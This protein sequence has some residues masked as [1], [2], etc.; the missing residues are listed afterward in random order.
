M[1]LEK[2]KERERFHW[3]KKFAIIIFLLHHN[4]LFGLYN[5]NYNLKYNLAN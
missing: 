1:K 4:C 3:T 5:T 2:V